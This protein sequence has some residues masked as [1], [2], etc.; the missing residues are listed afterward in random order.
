MPETFPWLDDLIRSVTEYYIVYQK[1]FL[2]DLV[3]QL[4]GVIPNTIT[5]ISDAVRTGGKVRIRL[6]RS[7]W[8]VIHCRRRAPQISFFSISF[9]GYTLHT[10]SNSMF[11]VMNWMTSLHRWCRAVIK[12]ITQNIQ[13][14]GHHGDATPKFT[15]WGNLIWGAQQSVAW[16]RHQMETF[17]ALLVI[18]AGNS[19]VTGEFPTQ[20]PVTRGFDIF[21][22]LRLNKRLSKQW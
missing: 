13:Q 15:T 19:P 1:R 4:A 12:F 3:G 9:R 11:C 6:I 17:S 22:D 10:S 18:C 14:I 2:A 5:A 16:W 7:I 20:R 8:E 21:F